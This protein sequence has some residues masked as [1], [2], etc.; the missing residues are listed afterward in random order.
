[1]MMMMM[2][3]ITI[4]IIVSTKFSN[5]IGFQQPLLIAWL[6]NTRTVI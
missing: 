5:L 3:I 6:M 2:I 4:I 1:M